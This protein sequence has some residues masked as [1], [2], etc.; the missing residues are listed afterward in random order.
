MILPINQTYVRI[1]MTIS[2]LFTSIKNNSGH[3]KKQQNSNESS[4]FEKHQQS[5]TKIHIVNRVKLEVK[6][7]ESLSNAVVV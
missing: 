3:S 7:R 4:I 5:L 1:L 6:I 2:G